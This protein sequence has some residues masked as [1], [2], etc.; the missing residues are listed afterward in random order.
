M[1]EPFDRWLE[2]RQVAWRTKHVATQLEGAHAGRPRPWILPDNAWEQGLWPGIRSGTANSLPDYLEGSRVQRHTG[3]N[4]LKSS[5]IMCANLYFPFRATEE[6]RGLIAT[7]LRERVAKQILSVVG[8]ELEFAEKEALHPAALLGEA[9]GA[10]GSGQTSPDVAFVVNGGK[11]LVLT[12]SKLGEHSFYSCSARTRT[13]TEKRPANPDP[14]RCENALVVLDNPASQCH[15][16]IWGRKYWETL[17]SVANR[18]AW[19]ALYCCPAAHAGYQL[20]RQ[21]ALAEGI[22]SSG[23]Y[24][25]VI[26]CVAMDERNEILAQ[27]L[28]KTGVARI[29]D[30]SHLFQGRARFAVFT[31]QQWVAWVRTNDDGAWAEWLSWVEARYG[32]A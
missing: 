24:D 6:S 4:N 12:E 18:E 25:L 28:R 8:L 32:L 10:R 21:Q 13:G 11:G 14:R 9:G 3:S 15:Q 31:H 27:S 2:R 30:W 23:K 7:F 29:N 22:A 20:F 16:V 1:S 5:W 26:S 19:S 17:G